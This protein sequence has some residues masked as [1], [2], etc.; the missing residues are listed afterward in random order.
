MGR[1]M[2]SNIKYLSDA[3][4]LLGDMVEGLTMKSKKLE[5]HTVGCV[6]KTQK[7]NWVGW[8]M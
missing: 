8:V 6:G 7:G 4:E 5:N 2:Y 1:E 3:S